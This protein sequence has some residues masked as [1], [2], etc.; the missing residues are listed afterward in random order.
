MGCY[1]DVQY[2]KPFD[3]DSAV[4]PDK[5]WIFSYPA[6]IRAESVAC[7]RD[8][9]ASGRLT[10]ILNSGRELKLGALSLVT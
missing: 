2:W 7:G 6:R 3:K 10:D 1:A 5:S 8:R 4:F 9:D